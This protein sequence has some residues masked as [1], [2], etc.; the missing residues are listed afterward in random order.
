M[1]V[2]SCS[3]FKRQHRFSI[4]RRGWCSKC[5]TCGEVWT[6]LSYVCTGGVVPSPPPTPHS[7]HRT[8]L[9]LSHFWTN[10]NLHISLKYS[11]VQLLVRVPCQMLG[12]APREFGIRAIEVL[13]GDCTQIVDG[14]YGGIIGRMVDAGT[15]KFYTLSK[16]HG[17]KG[18]KRVASQKKS[19]R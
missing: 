7:L 3:C 15:D 18:R 10:R 19:V 16:C 1:M 8:C 11:R 17:Y 6:E 14:S 4:R 5:F 9:L 13:D 12:W 2:E